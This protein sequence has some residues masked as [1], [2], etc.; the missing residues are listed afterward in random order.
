MATVRSV[1]ARLSPRGRIALGGAA[2]AIVVLL[3][4]MFQM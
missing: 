1:L 4:V 2:V 3:F